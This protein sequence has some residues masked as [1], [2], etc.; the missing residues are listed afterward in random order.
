MINK[1][2]YCRRQSE[3]CAIYCYSSTLHHCHPSNWHFIIK[4]LIFL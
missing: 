2:N 3:Y 1:W 4:E